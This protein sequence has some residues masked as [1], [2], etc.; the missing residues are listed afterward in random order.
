MDD[1]DLKHFRVRIID[2]A[3]STSRDFSPDWVVVRVHY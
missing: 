2:N 1:R 3:S